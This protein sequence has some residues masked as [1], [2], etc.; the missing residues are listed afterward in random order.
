MWRRATLDDADHIVAMC[1]ALNEEDP[2]THT[3]PEQYTR[4]TIAKLHREPNRGVIALLE[5]GTRPGGYAFLIPF[6]SNEL[7]GDVCVID[8]IFVMPA[9]RSHGHGRKLIEMVKQGHGV[10]PEKPVA[11]DLEVSPKN[12]RARALY[13]QL[14][15]K[16]IRNALMRFEP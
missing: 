8:E 12:K 5:D 1:K 9:L 3:V 14:G 7:G 15:F 11:V 4:Q 10:W 6:W 2:G 13:E 16:S